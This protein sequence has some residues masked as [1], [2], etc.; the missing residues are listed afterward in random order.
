[1]DETLE[2]A[3]LRHRLEV[4]ARLAQLDADAFHGADPESLADES[5]DVDSSR[6]HVAARLGRSDRDPRLL[7]ERLHSLGGD[8]RHGA[9]RRRVAVG[10]EVAVAD[11]A[12]ARD[13]TD[14]IDGL[15]HLA[16]RLRE[17]D[18]FDARVHA[19]DTTDRTRRHPESRS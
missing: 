7:D 1:M 16:V 5:V 13:G 11:E 4:G 19:G 9:A 8:Q 6:E 14:A 12:G 17:E 2:N 15:R 10:V 3:G 18:P